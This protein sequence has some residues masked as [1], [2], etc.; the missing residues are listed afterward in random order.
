[1]S[2]EKESEYGGETSIIVSTQLGSTFLDK[3]K[4]V[5]V[6]R[7]ATVIE[8]KR[9]LHQKFPGSPPVSLQRLFFGM[10]YLNDDDIIGNITTLNPIPLLLDM[11]TGTSVYDKTLSISQALEAYSCLHVQQA[12]VG[13]K[14]NSLFTESKSDNSSD[15]TTKETKFE[16]SIYRNMLE[17]MNKT[18]YEYYEEDIREATELEREPEVESADTL[19]WRQGKKDKVP[20]VALVAKEFD[21]NFKGLKNMLWYSIVL[22]VSHPVIFINQASFSYD[23]LIS[24]SHI[25][26]QPVRNQLWLC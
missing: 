14:L 10:K 22:G 13:D 21:I 18:L 2:K 4:R 23:I 15:T 1:V 6:P 11:L 5:K 3:K 24:Y 17:V 20:I 9:L 19:G 25:M 12:Y 8:L 7:N 16:T 26:V